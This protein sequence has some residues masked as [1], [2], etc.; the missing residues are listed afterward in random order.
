MSTITGCL[1][2]SIFRTTLPIS[3]VSNG[4]LLTGVPSTKQLNSLKEKFEADQKALQ[5]KFTKDKTE[6]DETI[7]I[8]NLE[9]EL[10]KAKNSL[11]SVQSPPAPG[12]ASGSATGSA[13]GMGGGRRRRSGARKSGA[14]R[15]KSKTK[16]RITRKKNRNHKKRTRRYKKQ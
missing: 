2:P 7:K 10:S 12:S 16:K 1:L 6:L 9:K 13:T 11:S 14:R 8:E 3:C 5:K 15:S 4:S